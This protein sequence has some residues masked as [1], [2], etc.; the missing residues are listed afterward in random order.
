ME[1]VTDLPTSAT[2]TVESPLAKKI[3]EKTAE[4]DNLR[5]Q[6]KFLIQQA[7]TC[8]Q[9]ILRAEGALAALQELKAQGESN[10]VQKD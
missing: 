3:V 2:E 4:L 6:N 7:T 10:G 9:E 1:A 8:Q 5:K